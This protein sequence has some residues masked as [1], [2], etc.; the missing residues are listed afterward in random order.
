MI[1]YCALKT[2]GNIFVDM[3]MFDRAIKVYK[4]LKDYCDEWGPTFLKMKMKAF[5]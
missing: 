4:T 2:L 3:N 1:L 5:E